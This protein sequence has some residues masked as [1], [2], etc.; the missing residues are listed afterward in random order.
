MALSSGDE[1]DRL[2]GPGLVASM[3]S[4]ESRTAPI[5]VLVRRERWDRGGVFGS[6][7]GL[8]LRRAARLIVKGLSGSL[9]KRISVA[10]WGFDLKW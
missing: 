6:K 3:V 10:G 9:R 7:P 8:G 1:P 2:L 5:D 4:A